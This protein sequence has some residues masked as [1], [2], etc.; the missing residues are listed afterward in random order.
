MS[1]STLDHCSIRTAKLPEA[2]NFYVDI[3]GMADGARPDFDFPGHWLYIGDRPVV[4]LIGIDTAAPE[5]LS[6]YLGGTVNPAA[7]ETTGTSAFDHVAFRAKDPSILMKRLDDNGY[8][9]RERMV[10][11]LELFQIFVEDP[12]GV[13][14]E[15]NYFAEEHK[16]A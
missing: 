3:L 9:Y 8:T 13:T 7:L 16:A 11:D 12:N 1:L 4:H 10:P 6:D 14:V 2:R 5:G 15:L